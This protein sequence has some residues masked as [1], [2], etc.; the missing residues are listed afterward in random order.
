MELRHLRY[1]AAV[2]DER[3]FSGAAQ[4]LL[5]SQSSLS[6]QIQ[7][8]ER[9]LGYDLFVR[10]PRGVV[11]TLAGEALLAHARQMLALEAETAHVLSEA[12]NTREA[13]A[14]GVPPGIPGSWLV[15]LVEAVREAVPNGLLNLTEATSTEQLRRME[16]GRLDLGIVHQVP[17]EVYET[18]VLWVE[19]LGVAVRP[20]HRLAAKERYELSDLDSLRVLAHSQDQV[21]TQQEGLLAATMTAQVWPRWQFCQ[22][23]EHALACAEAVGADAVLV[24]E[25][26]A[27]AQL[28]GWRWGPVHGLVPDMT[29]W[30]IRRQH[31]RPVVRDVAAAVAGHARAR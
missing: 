10:G 27:A 17:P 11:L 22:F 23:V 1:F 3:S 18:E 28:P 29:T 12:A 15:G 8:L 9:Q 24:A 19:P 20:G 6:R 30:L 5:L 4:R 26:T 2:A 31:A 14:V 13:V 7:A 16:R 21:P 25:H